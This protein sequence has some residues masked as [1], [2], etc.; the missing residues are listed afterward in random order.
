[1]RAVAPVGHAGPPAVLAGVPIDDVTLEEA[2]D[3]CRE[4]VELGRATGR[5]HQ[6]TTVNVDFV[7]TARRDPSVRRILQ[8]S[9]LAVP[10]G[11]PVVWASHLLGTPLRQRV[12]G[13]DL[14]P[15]LAAC[16]AERGYRLYLFGSAPGVA[17]R[18]ADR[19][20]EQ[21]PGARVV[22]AGGPMFEDVAEMDPTVLAD[23]V[24][25]KPDIVCVALGHP[26]QERWIDA[27]RE[28]V[29]APVLV[30]IGG[31]L[32]FLVGR[33][34]RAPAW[35]QRAGL[36]WLHRMLCEPQ[37]LGRRYVRDLVLFPALVLRELLASPS[38][39]PGTA[40]LEGRFARAGVNTIVDL[41]GVTRLDRIALG[42]LVARARRDR[43]SGGQLSVC[44][45]SHV[46]RRSVRAMQVEQYFRMPADA[47]VAAAGS[48]LAVPSAASPPP[49]TGR[50]S[51][52]ALMLDRTARPGRPIDHAPT[53]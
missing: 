50:R 30:G 22:G 11:M 12:A 38:R 43:A 39:A 40:A 35:M 23:I 46:A 34:R 47:E 17:E 3:R 28:Q 36:E 6:V 1:M 25:A 10:D 15:A 26:K 37:R 51:A 4:L 42:S 21:H 45:L 7:L 24:A 19:L 13:A 49:S 9:D 32:D 48:D 2:V 14:V 5:T 27:Y 53:S 16:A 8:W 20:C 29:G 52:S 18:A 44:G 31:S 33:K 41:S